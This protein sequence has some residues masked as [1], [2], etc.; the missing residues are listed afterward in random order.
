MPCVLG[1]RDRQ[2]EKNFEVYS[3]LFFFNFYHL[4][5]TAEMSFLGRPFSHDLLPK[6]GTVV[7][8]PQQIEENSQ[9]VVRG[10]F[11]DHAACDSWD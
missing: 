3:F 2:G 1:E 5:F 6:P 11:L 8:K 4:C 7:R 9:L 10:F